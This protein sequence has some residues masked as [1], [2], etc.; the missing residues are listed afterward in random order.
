MHVIRHDHISANGNLKLVAGTE[1]VLPKRNVNEGE[2][3]NPNPVKRAKRDE[4]KR[5]IIGLE[6]LIE[7][8]RTTFDHGRM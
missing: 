2:P 8:R 5:R 3:L 7:S 1:C 6:N 4:E